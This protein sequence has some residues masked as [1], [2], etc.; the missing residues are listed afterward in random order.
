MQRYLLGT[1]TADIS[2]PKHEI[3]RE[4]SNSRARFTLARHPTCTK[5]PD[6]HS[7]LTYRH[8]ISDVADNTGALWGLG[9]VA[10]CRVTLELQF[11][12]D[13]LK[14]CLGARN[15]A[16]LFMCEKALHFTAKRLQLQL[17]CFALWTT[18]DHQWLLDVQRFHAG[19]QLCVQGA[20]PDEL[21]GS[22][23]NPPAPTWEGPH[24]SAAL[25]VA[26]M[27][28][29]GPWA[30]QGTTPLAFL[31]GGVLKVR[32]LA[33]LRLVRGGPTCRGRNLSTVLARSGV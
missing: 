27:L 1:L 33:W 6:T 14:D 10:V 7:S 12:V 5:A 19:W 16:Q 25:A 4:A 20:G 3:Y 11:H 32:R 17:L 18:W 24:E 8:P 31:R 13:P 28:G 30:W 21:A 22:L 29:A 2:K 15:M 23:A 26:I 9:V